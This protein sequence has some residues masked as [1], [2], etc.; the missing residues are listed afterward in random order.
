MSY[1]VR[2]YT[3]RASAGS[4]KLAERVGTARTDR[5]PLTLRIQPPAGARTVR[6]VLTAE[7]PIGNTVSVKRALSLPR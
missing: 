1:A 2:V 4:V 6:L 3:H 5:V 7:D